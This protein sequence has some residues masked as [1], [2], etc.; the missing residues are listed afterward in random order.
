MS[1]A[2]ANTGGVVTQQV[3]A[4]LRSDDPW[5]EITEGESHFR[6]LKPGRSSSGPPTDG[7]PTLRLRDGFVGVH[8]AALTLEIYAGETLLSR[9]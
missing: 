3:L 9:F 1:F 7:Y 6:D 2:L 4:L 8:Q 5:V